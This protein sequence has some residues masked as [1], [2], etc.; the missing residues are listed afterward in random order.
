MLSLKE[1]ISYIKDAKEIAGVIGTAM[2]MEL[3]ALNPIKSI[4]L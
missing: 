3:F 4:V 2:H 1:Q